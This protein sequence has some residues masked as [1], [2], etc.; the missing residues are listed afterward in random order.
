MDCH[1][2]NRLLIR[3][4]REAEELSIIRAH[5]TLWS[6]LDPNELTSQH[7]S[8]EPVA[9]APAAH[10]RTVSSLSERLA[11]SNL[12]PAPWFGEHLVPWCIK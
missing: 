4:Q 3:V 11:D 2:S 9:A 7:P 8:H 1:A 10:T 6:L 12:I 5:V